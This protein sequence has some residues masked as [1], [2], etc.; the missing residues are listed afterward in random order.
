VTIFVEGG[1]D[2]SSLKSQCRQAFSDLLRN[3]GFRDRMPSKRALGGRSAAFDAFTS[4]FGNSVPGIFLVLLVDSETIPRCNDPWLHLR[5]QAG[6]NKPHGAI[7]DHAHLMVVC[8][9]TWLMSD[10]E[11]LEQYFGSGFK[12]AKLP[13][14][15]L[16]KRSK[17]DIY[18][19]I[20]RATAITKPK[21]KYG[22]A[23]D[24][25]KLLS[26]IDPNKLKK[27]CEWAARFFDA[28]ER[29]C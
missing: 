18:D 2:A 10:P 29:H 8:M 23:R 27:S 13:P 12:K 7:D 15:D 14:T 3:A 17:S 26:R 5:E 11:A 25:F 22:K 28:L 4:A 1:R 19:A 21:G 16:E 9:E 20:D 6:W 24:S